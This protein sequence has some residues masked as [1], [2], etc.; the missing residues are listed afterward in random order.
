MAI[1]RQKVLIV[2]GGIGGLASALALLRRGDEVT[3]F[4][5]AAELREVGAGLTIAPNAARALATLGLGEE[6]AAMGSITLESCNLFWETGEELAR[7]KMGDDEYAR[8]FGAP[9][10]HVHR[11]DL[12]A[13]LAAAVERLSPGAV[14][15]NSTVVG[16]DQDEARATLTLADG[17]RHNGDL[18]IGA[19]GVRSVVYASLFGETPPTFTHRL[20][21]R[22]VLPAAAMEGLALP[23]NMG[24]ILGPDRTLAWYKLRDETQLNLV[25]LSR[26]DEW[27]D[28][29]W[30]AR[31][32]VDDVRSA[33]AGWCKLAQDVIDRLPAEGV[34][35]WGLFDRPPYDRWSD[36]RIVCVGDAVHAMLPYMGQGAAMA[37]E[38]AVV[39]SRALDAE[40]DLTAALD[41]FAEVRKPRTDWIQTA[42]RQR[43][44][45]WERRI[46]RNRAPA[47]SRTCT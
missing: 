45:F 24:S 19:D 35:R 40:D 5:Q 21:W 23:T 36:G 2:G 9:Y 32:T 1:A 29:D 25:F 31:G 13:A 27:V 11:A 33:Y 39:L 26:C 37:I 42:S 15:V 47:P 22:A 44:D 17:T 28:E 18:I 14:R 12:H 20:A 41:L 16:I 8:R 38:D 7:R 4:E 46:R 6:L 34:L 30:R 3:V 10:Y 43:A